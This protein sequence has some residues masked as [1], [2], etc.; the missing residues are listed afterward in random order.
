MRILSFGHHG[1]IRPNTPLLLQGQAF[2]DAGNPLTGGHLKWFANR[3]R[4]GTGALLTA[5]AL[6]PGTQRIRLV[7]TDA[8]GRSSHAQLAV[9]ILAAKPVFLVARAPSKVSATAHRIRMTV[10][11]S[12]PAVLRIAGVRHAIGRKPRVIT[13]AIRPGRSTLRLTYSLSAP[14][15]TSTGTYVAAR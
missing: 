11:S 14:G 15:G 8:H 5:P 12:V 1:Q 9:R 6:P 10:A 13:I 7:A 4:I 2:D 3:R